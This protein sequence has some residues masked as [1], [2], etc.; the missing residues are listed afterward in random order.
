MQ[1]SNIPHGYINRA[2]TEIVFRVH[3]LIICFVI[4]RVGL[5]RKRQKIFSSQF[6]KKV[7]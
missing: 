4:Y 5:V 1:N 2:F 6:K 3:K 7:L